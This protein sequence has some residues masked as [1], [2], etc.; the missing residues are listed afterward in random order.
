M[1]RLGQHFLK[2]KQVLRQIAAALDIKSGDAIIEIGPGH[3]E[4]TRQLVMNNDK[5]AIKVTAIE[6][7]IQLAQRLKSEFKNNK[8]VEI[9]AGDA[10]K[11]LPSVVKNSDCKIVGNIPY[12]ITGHL[13]RILS[14]LEHKPERIALLIQ[15]E[16]A[17][18]MCAE[19][20][21][22]NLLAA[23]TQSWAEPK[24]I[25][26]VGKG[27]FSPPPK[28][29]SAII[30][31]NPQPRIPDPRYFEFIH[32]LFKQPRKTIGNNLMTNEKL[33]MMKDKWAEKLNSVGINPGDRAQNLSSEQI[34][35][36]FLA[37]YNQN[38]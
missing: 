33:L 5:T 24:I 13:L 17:E 20:P 9:L 11:K 10:L 23:I 16:V 15:K 31:L 2:N 35:N 27:D 29:D 4:L 18:R 21:K 26:R 38:K 1:Q 25:A 30:V 28:I 7:D 34:H 6:K 36:L 14:E 19:P 22:M 8:N 3:G 37:L 12:Y 32:T